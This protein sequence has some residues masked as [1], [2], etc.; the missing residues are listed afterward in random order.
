MI[1]D[2]VLSGLGRTLWPGLTPAWNIPADIVVLGKGLANGLAPVSAVMVDP[3]LIARI[4]DAGDIDH[5]HTHTNHPASLGAAHGCLT[6]LTRLTHDPNVLQ[7]ALRDA[8]VEAR[9]LGWLATV[10]LRPT[11]RRHLG[12]VLLDAGLLGHVPTMVDPVDRLVIAPPLISSP[13][14]IATMTSRLAAVLAQV[15]RR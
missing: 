13:D 6:A 14:E 2:E 9:S 12:Q 4:S 7:R 8:G 10:D 1:L 11:G 15:G 5:G 3:E